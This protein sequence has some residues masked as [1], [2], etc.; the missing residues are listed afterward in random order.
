VLFVPY[1]SYRGRWRAALT[2][3]AAT[4]AF[5]LSPILVFGWERFADYVV[6]WRAMVARGWGVGKMNQSVFAMLDRLIG[7]GMAP[8]S[9]PGRNGVPASGD[10]WVTVALAAVVLVVALLGVRTFRGWIAPG[11]WAAQ[12]EWSIV[13][14]CAAIFGPVAWKAYLVVLLLPNTLLFAVARARPLAGPTRAVAGIAL[15]LSFALA[16]LASRPL[17]GKWTADALEMSSVVTVA[18]LVMLAGLFWTRARLGPNVG[19]GGLDPPNFAP[20]G[21]MC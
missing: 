14:L 7:H 21:K 17:V 1:L 11:G 4:A 10:P 15:G 18:A 13:F 8:L 12:A 20:S 16:Q 5:S 6:A 2:A 3:G 9:E 19:P